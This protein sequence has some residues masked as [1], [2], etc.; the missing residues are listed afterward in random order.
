MKLECNLFL[1]HTYIMGCLCVLHVNAN[2][3]V[4]MN[5]TIAAQPK[6]ASATKTYNKEKKFV[7]EISVK[8]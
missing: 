6:K 3:E 1:V 8:C 5:G 4:C 2:T 7:A